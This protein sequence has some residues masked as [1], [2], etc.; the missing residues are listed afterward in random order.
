MLAYK[1]KVLAC[2]VC[3]NGRKE[4]FFV[5]VWKPMANG[6]SARFGVVVHVDCGTGDVDGVG[7]QY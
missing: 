1:V 7:K 5:Y 3:R 4:R 6:C 2:H